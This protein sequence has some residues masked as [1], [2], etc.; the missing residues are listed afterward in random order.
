M[1]VCLQPSLSN[2]HEHLTFSFLT[3]NCSVSLQLLSP[4]NNLLRE[5]QRHT[6]C[7]YVCDPYGSGFIEA[8]KE[9]VYIRIPSLYFHLDPSVTK[10]AHPSGQPEIIGGILRLIT[11]SYHL[12]ISGKIKMFS[13]FI[14]HRL[15]PLPLPDFSF[16]IKQL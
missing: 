16:C 10:V 14:P 11:K 3:R 6:P 2:L 12:H 1:T 8:G 4:F 9:A 13:Y 15:S 7:F 5:I